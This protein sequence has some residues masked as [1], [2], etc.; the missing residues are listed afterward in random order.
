MKREDEREDS[1]EPRHSSHSHKRKEREHSEERELED[2]RVRVS[3]EKKEVK[4]E[5]RKFGDKVKKEEEQENGDN[6]GGF[7][8]H[9][10]EVK[11]KE[12]A[13]DGA[14]GSASAPMRNGNALG[15]P[16]GALPSLP[17]TSLAPS[18]PVPIKMGHL[19]LLENLEA[20]LLMP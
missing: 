3:D 8:V 6:I 15:S 2:K 5:R 10:N 19:Q 9:V 20:S 17:E 7:Q 12:E 14:R 11:V 16:A 13:T 1:V 18:P 4:R